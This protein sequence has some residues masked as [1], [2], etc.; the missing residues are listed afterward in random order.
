MV[1]WENNDFDSRFRI[2]ARLRSRFGVLGPVR[3]SGW[4]GFNPAVAIG[5]SGAGLVVWENAP[6]GAGGANVQIYNLRASGEAG[7]LQNV[8]APGEEGQSPE[9]GI[10]GRG[11]ALIKWL[12]PVGFNFEVRLRP[13]QANSRLGAVETVAT[14]FN[15]AN[16]D[17]A[18]R[19]DG[20][21]LIVWAY[22]RPFDSYN[23][24]RVRLA[25][26]DLGTARQLSA[27]DTIDPKI[28]VNAS[29]RSI[30]AWIKVSPDLRRTETLEGAIEQ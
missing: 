14:L 10:D 29:G 24:Y 9:V 8:T 26:G 11:N 22:Q 5:S 23:E 27:P 13:M 19:P 28:A 25:L 6:R 2:R 21:S 30:A 7:R 18:V 17:L 16:S 15:A 3:S 12:H 4:G 20:S 1:A